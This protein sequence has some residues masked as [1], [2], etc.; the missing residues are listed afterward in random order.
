MSRKILLLMA[1]LAVFAV[2]GL[3]QSTTQSTPYNGPFGGPILMTPNAS[4]PNPPPAAGI[5]D[6]GRAGI[7]A[8][9]SGTA[10]GEAVPM[11]TVTTTKVTESVPVASE[12]ST[13][14]PAEN[15]AT[16]GL[17]P[18]VSVND[19]SAVTAPVSVAEAATRYKT[20]K[21]TLNARV[22]SNEDVQL[23]VNRNSSNR[24]MAV[25]MPPTMPN[26]QSQSADAQAGSS[27]ASSVQTGSAPSSATA[28]SATSPSQ[29][30]P[31]DAQTNADNA[32]TP[33]I[34][35]NQQ[36]NDS[37][38]TTRLPATST[39]L[40]LLGLL[41]LASGGFGLLVRKFRK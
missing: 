15:A 37:Q 12:A 17:N 40:P 18:S 39:F 2:S 33:Q 13:A 34:N 5:S 32:T 6:A 30:Q 25:N 21:T 35:Q 41:G 26:G 24:S 23:I 28:P 11:T 22:I 9:P 4:F 31:A 29:V 10:S 38:G 3:G 16:N 7:S 14:A 19:P 36:S 8:N 1:A 20:D 27:Q